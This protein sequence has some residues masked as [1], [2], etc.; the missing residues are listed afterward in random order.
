MLLVL[1]IFIRSGKSATQ[2]VD[3]EIKEEWLMI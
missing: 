3:F 2:L 1:V